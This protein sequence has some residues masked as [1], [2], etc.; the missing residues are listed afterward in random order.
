MTSNNG[1][2]GTPPTSKLTT[3]ALNY[4]RGDCKRNTNQSDATTSSIASTT[5]LHSENFLETK[6]LHER[7]PLKPLSERLSSPGK[8][9]DKDF[10]TDEL[11]E[12]KYAVKGVSVNFSRI[13]KNQM[14]LDGYRCLLKPEFIDKL[15]RP[16][17]AASMRREYM[18]ILQYIDPNLRTELITHIPRQ[19]IEDLIP[20]RDLKLEDR[21]KKWNS[22]YNRA[23]VKI[24]ILLAFAEGSADAAE[25][26]ADILVLLKPFEN[27]PI[28]LR[29]H[30]FLILQLPI[31]HR[32][33][34]LTVEFV[35]QLDISSEAEIKEW[36]SIG[37]K[38]RLDI[39]KILHNLQKSNKPEI[40]SFAKKLFDELPV[41]LL[42]PAITQAERLKFMHFFIGIFPELKV[43][44]QWINNLASSTGQK[45]EDIYEEWRALSPD[46]IAQRLILLKRFAINPQSA[47]HC[48]LTKIA[49]A[50]AYFKGIPKE[51]PMTSD[52]RLFVDV[53]RVEVETVYKE[54]VLVAKFATLEEQ[55]QVTDYTKILFD[56]GI[57]TE[58]QK[59]LMSQQIEIWDKLK[60]ECTKKT[61][62]FLEKLPAVIDLLNKQI[63]DVNDFIEKVG[64]IIKITHP[65]MAR[66]PLS[67][68]IRYTEGSDSLFNGDSVLKMLALQDRVFRASSGLFSKWKLL[69]EYSSK[70][71]LAVGSKLLA[72]LQA[73]SMHT[74]FES[75]TINQFKLDMTD[76]LI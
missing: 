65:S 15:K 57:F 24:G 50:I 49:I 22:D 39:A 28:P 9:I 60:K 61:I 3:S 31:I 52:L 71:Q 38:E 30:L 34:L 2:G 19:W 18:E 68:L 62:Q 75:H 10:S 48:L 41:L 69:K 25:M 11:F 74:W 4:D 36:L 8:S 20:R 5:L 23:K 16:H 46:E 70:E 32:D 42:H 76:W 40:S 1:I 21:I 14:R 45:P 67:S 63:A 51:K 29:D 33:S 66:D 44:N 55:R 37:Y 47:V 58:R 12:F 72:S 13:P 59:S 56:L 7:S 27:Y 6:T 73:E 54:W 17:I 35:K 53:W 43:P 26:L 64:K